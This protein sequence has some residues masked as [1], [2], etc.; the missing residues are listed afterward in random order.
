MSLKKLSPV[1]FKE[2]DIYILLF[3]KVPLRRFLTYFHRGP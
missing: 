3:S 1:S 2:S